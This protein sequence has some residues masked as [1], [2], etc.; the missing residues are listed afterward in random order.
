MPV[1]HLEYI[2]GYIHTY[3][4]ILEKRMEKNKKKIKGVKIK[5]W[6]TVYSTYTTR[7]CSNSL[8]ALPSEA[9]AEPVRLIKLHARSRYVNHQ[10]PQV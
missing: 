10:E 3:T 4:Y 8:V 6:K 1:S 5:R 7:V 2:D 9:V